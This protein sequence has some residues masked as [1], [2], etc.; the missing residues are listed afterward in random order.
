MRQKQAAAEDLDSYK[1]ELEAERRR[2]EEL[3]SRM[4][5]LI[6]ETKRTRREAEESERLG[7]IREGLQERGVR[8]V[9]LA[10][11]LMKDDVKREAD[12]TLSGELDGERA[13]IDEYMNRFLAENPEFLPPR[14][15]GGAGATGKTAGELS[16][17]GVDLES[18][19]PGMSAEDAKRA[20]Q[21]VARLM[22]G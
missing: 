6:E 12:G 4:R 18:I 14:I 5:E 9:G 16:L 8:K 22:G 11:R 19:R 15:A 13:P 2:R 3:E 17:S 20:W 10:L 7:R 1:E 21:E